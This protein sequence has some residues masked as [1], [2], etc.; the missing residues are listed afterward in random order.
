MVIIGMRSSWNLV[1]QSVQEASNLNVISF[2]IGIMAWMIRKSV[3]SANLRGMLDTSGGHTDY[4]KTLN[5][6][7]N[8]EDRNVMEF[9]KEKCNA[10]H[11]GRSYP[12]CQCI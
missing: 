2:T 1:I 5:R 4:Q 9:N 8:W 10:L 6:V 7:N 12:T 11:L 3:P